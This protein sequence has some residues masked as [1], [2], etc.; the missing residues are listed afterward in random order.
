[1]FINWANAEVDSNSAL[2]VS[3]YGM[4]VY[5][6]SGLGDYSINAEYSTIGFHIREKIVPSIAAL[7]SVSPVKW[8]GVDLVYGLDSTKFKAVASLDLPSSVVNRSNVP[9]DSGVPG[10]SGENYSSTGSGRANLG[11]DIYTFSIPIEVVTSIRS[12]LIPFKQIPGS[13]IINSIFS[14][15]MYAGLGMNLNRGSAG[16]IANSSLEV[17]ADAYADASSLGLS[18]NEKLGDVSVGQ[19]LNLGNKAKPHIADM[20][21]LGG[22]T[23]NIGPAHLYLAGSANLFYSAYSVRIGTS[24]D[25]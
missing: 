24:V 17:E 18:S 25:F 5:R 21:V 15:T 23:T 12:G 8:N 3:V 16:A 22:L 9:F 1:L 14:F 6:G 2:R 11:V 7:N 4:D 20:R 13:S 19:S 10:L